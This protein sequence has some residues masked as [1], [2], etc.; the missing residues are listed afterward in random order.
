MYNYERKTQISWIISCFC[1]RK[2]VKQT[3][4]RGNVV[5]KKIKIKKWLENLCHSLSYNIS[6]VSNSMRCYIKLN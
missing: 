2:D 6:F 5:D 1:R 4:L 3:M